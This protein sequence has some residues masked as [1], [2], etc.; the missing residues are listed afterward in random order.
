[1]CDSSTEEDYT[2]TEL[3]C[4]AY[5]QLSDDGYSTISA[6]IDI[7]PVIERKTLSTII[8]NFD[9]ICKHLRRVAEHVSS[10]VS[11]ELKRKTTLHVSARSTALC[12]K[13]IHSMIDI[14]RVLQRYVQLYV[15]CRECHS[16]NT[17]LEREKRVNILRCGDCTC[18]YSVLPFRD[19]LISQHTT[20]LLL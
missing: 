9:A 4:R 17:L 18:L 14:E 1:M 8:C 15:E 20:R 10:F 19:L 5:T 11:V 6:S 16:R 3:L 7:T 12:I 13:G 2:Y